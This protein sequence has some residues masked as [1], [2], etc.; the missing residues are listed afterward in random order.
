MKNAEPFMKGHP[1]FYQV[2]TAI[3]VNE[4]ATGIIG[5]SGKPGIIIFF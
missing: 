2:I 1:F 3:F 5:I 4:A